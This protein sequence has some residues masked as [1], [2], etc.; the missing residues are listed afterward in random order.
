MAE[1]QYVFLKLAEEEYGIDILHVREIINYQE[2]TKLPNTSNVIDGVINFRG[3]IIPVINLKK[4]FN[5]NETIVKENSKIIIVNMREINIG[6][7]VDEA[8]HISTLDEK[9]IE[10]SLETV[11]GMDQKYIAGIGRMNGKIV[12]LLNLSEIISL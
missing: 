9:D 7:I 1:K 11:E 8:S 6:L 4:R 10:D 12:I 5:Y 2:T 3:N